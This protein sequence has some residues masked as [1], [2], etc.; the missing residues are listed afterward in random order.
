MIISYILFNCKF[1]M[2]KCTNWFTLIEIIVVIW[3]I[4]LLVFFTK[5]IWFSRSTNKQQS[6]FFSNEVYTNIEVVR[7]NSLLWKW[8]L[9]GWSLTYPN[10]WIIHLETN[11]G[12]WKILWYYTTGWPLLPHNDFTVKWIDSH[13]KISKLTCFDIAWANP[14][15]VSSA[16]IEFVW[17]T[18]SLSW[19]TS[20]NNK[21]LDIETTY[22]EFSRIIRVNTV[23]WLIEKS[24][25]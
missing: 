17:N 11:T 25:K 9:N 12:T 20:P 3:L 1:F 21:I 2:K 4:G 23:S 19:C 10:K 22:K 16:Q 13:S 24:D 7:N 14:N 15:V 18:V 6:L 8:V 5:D